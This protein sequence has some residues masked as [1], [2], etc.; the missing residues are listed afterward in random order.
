MRWRGRHLTLTTRTD[1]LRCRPLWSASVCCPGR[2]GAPR[3]GRAPFSFRR[4]CQKAAIGGPFAQ[5]PIDASVGL[6]PLKT[7]TSERVRILAPWCPVDQQAR[8][9]GLRCGARRTQ[10]GPRRPRRS[11]ATDARCDARRRTRS[12]GRPQEASPVKDRT[13]P[14]S[15]S[16]AL[17]QHGCDRDRDPMEPSSVYQMLS[18]PLTGHLPSAADARQPRLPLE[19]R[20]T[21][22]E[23]AMTKHLVRPLLL[24]LQGE[25]VVP[26]G[27]LSMPVPTMA[28]PIPSPTRPEA[29]PAAIGK[30]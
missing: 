15:S 29:S 21:A 18:L 26:R 4:G 25:P 30:R 11:G 16:E 24:M 7:I 22:R 3:K 27:E 12:V 19:Q 14:S 2:K 1:S 20:P 28:R 17:Q 13:R 5:C 9:P 23:S 10:A 6:C 8:F